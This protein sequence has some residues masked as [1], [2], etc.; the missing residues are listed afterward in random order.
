[1][2]IHRKQNRGNGKGNQA[3]RNSIYTRESKV[4]GRR[5]FECS[6]LGGSDW[7]LMTSYDEETKPRREIAKDL[8]N[9]AIS[10][11]R[12]Q[13]NTRRGNRSCVALRDEG[14][15]LIQGGTGIY[16]CRHLVSL[17]P[18]LA[19]L[20]VC[21][22]MANKLA[23]SS[24]SRATHPSCPSSISRLWNLIQSSKHILV[25]QKLCKSYAIVAGRSLLEESLR[26]GPEKRVNKSLAGCG[27]A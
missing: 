15:S 3:Q 25:M 1:L 9:S 22:R 14:F 17:I 27:N 8:A 23:R 5:M 20:A 21:L 7:S 26:C 10:N 6:R 18:Q 2:K 24:V 13:H 4:E 16:T 11:K 12:T 19:H